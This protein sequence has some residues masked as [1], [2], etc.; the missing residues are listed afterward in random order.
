M[1][2]PHPPR[3]AL[4]GLPGAGKSTTAALLRH[5]LQ[6]RGERTA[7]VRIAAPLGEVEAYLGAYTTGLESDGG[8]G[9]L[10]RIGDERLEVLA[11]ALT[12]LIWPFEIVEGEALQAF[13]GAF[14][15]R[16]RPADA[17]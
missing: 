2:T 17:G 7:V 9:T 10:W 16:L 15:G 3:I 1:T 8:G 6:E 13:V 11:G 12:W 4:F 5:A 14:V